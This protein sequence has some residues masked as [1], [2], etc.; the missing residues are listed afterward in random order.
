MCAS[1]IIPLFETSF[2]EKNFCTAKTTSRLQLVSLSTAQ[3]QNKNVLKAGSFRVASLEEQ[4][5]WY[6]WNPVIFF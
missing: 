2:F 4:F 3:K 1:K 6:F 5:A